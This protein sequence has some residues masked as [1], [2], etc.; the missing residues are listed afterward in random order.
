MFGVYAQVSCFGAS[1]L[2][3]VDFHPV[4]TLCCPLLVMPQHKDV[5]L[6]EMHTALRYYHINTYLCERKVRKDKEKQEKEEKER[7]RSVLESMNYNRVNLRAALNLE[8]AIGPMSLWR[9][10]RRL[11]PDEQPDED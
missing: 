8:M 5:F 11:Q 1:S 6:D 9:P 2:A 10:R 7:K 3:R 4:L